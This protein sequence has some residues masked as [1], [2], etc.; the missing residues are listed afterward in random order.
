MRKAV[1][2]KPKTYWE[3]IA[4]ADAHRAELHK[5]YPDQWVVIANEQVVAA[6]RNPV[7]VVKEAVK[8]TR[9]SPDEITL[10]FIEGVSAIYGTG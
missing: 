10:P 3:D 4:W 7:K 1:E 6:G 8:K 5:N 9:R 2:I